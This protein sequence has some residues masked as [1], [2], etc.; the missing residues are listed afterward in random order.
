MDYL[1][2]IEGVNW[3]LETIYPGLIKS[4]PGVPVFL[5]GKNMPEEIFKMANDKLK[6]SGR[7]DDARNYLSDKQ[8][9][10]VPLLSGGGM[11]VKI[12]EGMAMGKTI[13]ST[14]VGAEGIKYKHNKNILI[15]DTP[16][17][18]ID[19]IIHCVNNPDVA[20]AIGIEARNLSEKTYEN[21]IIGDNMLKFYDDVS[22]RNS[23]PSVPQAV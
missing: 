9:M 7:I 16:Q 17:E 20:K 15:A 14:T 8:I 6:V 18:F 4:T 1:P 12:I 19:A 21:K 22:N 11:R 5:A 3:F 23:V 13:I 2:N 10:I